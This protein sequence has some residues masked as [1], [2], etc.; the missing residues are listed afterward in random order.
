MN[1]IHNMPNIL[2]SL[3]SMYQ[4]IYIHY[5]NAEV[6]CSQQNICHPSI[7][8]INIR[9]PLS[10]FILTRIFRNSTLGIYLGFFQ[11]KMGTKYQPI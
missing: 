1:S 3:S 10:L 11:M 9:G 4:H 5:H 8:C 2:K 7:M 6:F